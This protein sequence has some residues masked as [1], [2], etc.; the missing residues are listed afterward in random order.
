M[1]C[2]AFLTKS[3]GSI[4]RPQPAHTTVNVLSDEIYGYFTDFYGDDFIMT[5]IRKY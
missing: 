5:I 3:F 4:L 2:L 1:L